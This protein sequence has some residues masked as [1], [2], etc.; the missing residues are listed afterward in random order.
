MILTNPLEI[1]K[2]RLQMSGE[3]GPNKISAI[4]IIR[5]L[6]FFGLYKGARACMMRDIVF[7]SIYFSTYSNVKASMAD[8]NG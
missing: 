7:S 1:V 2:I 6:G 5:D 4:S 3:A 8:E